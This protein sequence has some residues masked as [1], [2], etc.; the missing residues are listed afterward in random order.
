MKLTAS[1]ARNNLNLPNG[2]K[3][4]FYFSKNGVMRFISH[5]DLMRLFSRAARRAELP[6]FISKGFNPH[7]KIKIK[8]ALKLGIESNREEA[9]ILLTKNIPLDEFCKRM[10]KQLP[11]G[12]RVWLNC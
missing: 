3:I 5:L 12:I 2:I 1:P 8:Q 10:N 11:E 7:P 4:N 6:L 9:E